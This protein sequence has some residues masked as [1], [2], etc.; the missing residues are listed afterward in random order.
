MIDFI[1]RDFEDDPEPL[2]PK[3]P[4]VFWEARG[5]Y[6][7]ESDEWIFSGSWWGYLKPEDLGNKFHYYLDRHLVGG[8]R[9]GKKKRWHK[10]SIQFR[11]HSQCLAMV[12][13]ARI[14]VPRKDILRVMTEE[15]QKF[16]QNRG[17]INCAWR[18]AATKRVE[19]FYTIDKEG[20][21]TPFVTTIGDPKDA[22]L[23]GYCYKQGFIPSGQYV[24]H[25]RDCSGQTGWLRHSTSPGSYC[26]STLSDRDPEL[27]IKPTQM[28]IFPRHYLSYHKPSV[29]PEP[30][31]KKKKRICGSLIEFSDL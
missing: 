28:P 7:Y 30:Q 14:T 23:Y 25:Y 24:S 27:K 17:R 22:F 31:P 6:A 12:E 2:G 15:I 20:T 4:E 10:I 8:P 21:L 16:E 9:G 29:Y 5:G 11:I 1:R 18:E 26:G 13:I 3:V 19:T